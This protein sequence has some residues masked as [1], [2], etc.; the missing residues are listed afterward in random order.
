M[1]YVPQIGDVMSIPAG[2]GQHAKAG[3]VAIWN[4]RYWVSDYVQ[5]N[6]RGNTAA[7]NDVSYANI[8]KGVSVS[9]IARMKSSETSN[10]KN[11]NQCTCKRKYELCSA[12]LCISS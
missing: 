8:L 5:K 11:G 9:T 12:D 6:T 7:T 4:G 10:Q 2:R 3:H 1:D